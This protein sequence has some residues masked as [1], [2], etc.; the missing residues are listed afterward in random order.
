M[1]QIFLDCDAHVDRP[2]ISVEYVI[3]AGVELDLLL[4]CRVVLEQ[5]PITVAWRLRLFV[6]VLIVIHVSL[7]SRLEIDRRLDVSGILLREFH[8]LS[9]PRGQSCCDHASFARLCQLIQLVQQCVR[10][11]DLVV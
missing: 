1:S 2:M 3:F 7:I 5:N 9:L 11:D 4:K 8:R 6:L 10:Y